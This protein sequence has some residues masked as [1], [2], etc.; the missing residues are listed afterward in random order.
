MIWD[1]RVLQ[2][3]AVADYYPEHRR[4]E[5]VVIAGDTPK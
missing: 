4:M 5:R 2:H 3:N 1:N